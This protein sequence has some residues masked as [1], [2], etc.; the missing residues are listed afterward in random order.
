MIIKAIG[1]ALGAPAL[2]L[3]LSPVAGADP[4]SLNQAILNTQPTAYYPLTDPP[5]STAAADASGNSRRSLQVLTADSEGATGTGLAFTGSGVDFGGLD[6]LGHGPAL[7]FRHPD[8]W[9]RTFSVMSWFTLPDA[10]AEQTVLKAEGWEATVSASGTLA[11]C[12]RENGTPGVSL[13]GTQE[14]QLVLTGHGTQMSVYVDGASVEALTMPRLTRGPLSLG[15][16]PGLAGF[17]TYT[18]TEDHVA[19]WK[20]ELTPDEI[21]A[22]WVAGSA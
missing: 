4:V 7:G 14:H 20:R 12:C 11:F 18:G 1:A 15:S 21:S 22:M 10:T 13:V 3:A 17:N 5:G 2:V 8:G 9:R 19:E 6:Y 16:F